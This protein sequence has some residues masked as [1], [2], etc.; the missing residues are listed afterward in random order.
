MLCAYY[1]NPCRAELIFG[2]IEIHQLAFDMQ[3]MDDERD[4]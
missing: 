1:I 4:G 3:L 2:S